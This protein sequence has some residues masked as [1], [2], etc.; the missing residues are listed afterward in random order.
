MKLWLKLLET[1]EGNRYSVT[2]STDSPK[3]DEPIQTHT[4]TYQAKK[5]KQK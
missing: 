5:I 2:G 1:E 3:Q 4:K